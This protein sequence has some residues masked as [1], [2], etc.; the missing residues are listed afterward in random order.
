MLEC[1]WNSRL[2]TLLPE[3][4]KRVMKTCQKAAWNYEVRG[5]HSGGDANVGLLNRDD[6]STCRWVPTFGGTHRLRLQG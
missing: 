3:E 5:S 2:I 6:V 4:V 1:V